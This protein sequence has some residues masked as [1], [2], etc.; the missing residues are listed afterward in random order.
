M[1]KVTKDLMKMFPQLDEGKAFDVH[2]Q[3]M[4]DGVDFSEISNYE[5][6]QEAVKIIM[7]F[8]F[9]VY[10]AFYADE[11]AKLNGYSDGSMGNKISSDHPTY[12]KS[13]KLGQRHAQGGK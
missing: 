3:L 12:V 6:R 10:C 8:F 9:V 13:Y 7:N 4:C 1:N 11:K 2:M 5:L